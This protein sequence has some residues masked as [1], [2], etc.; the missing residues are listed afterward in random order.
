MKSTA[1]RFRSLAPAGAVPTPGRLF[2]SVLCCSL[3][4]QTTMARAQFSPIAPPVTSSVSGQFVVSAPAQFSWLFN[5]PEIAANTN[6]IRL[7]PALLAVA[8]ERFKVLLWQQV[9]LKA[10]SPWQGKVHLMLRAARSPEDEVTIASSFMSGSWSYQVLLPDVL[11]RARY[12][13]ALSAVL[14]LEI[15][16]RAN[17]SPNRSPEIPAWLVDGLGRQ[18]LDEDEAKLIL[19]LPAGMPNGAPMSSV[20]ERERGL[21]ALASA[22]TI[23]QNSA[24][25]TFD[26]LSWPTEEQM[27]GDDG[28]VYRASAQL[29]VHE[30]LRLPAGPE[31]IHFL[32]ARL[33]GCLN[34]QLA[35]YEAYRSE[36][37]RP[38]EVEKWWSLR[39]I[40]FAAH[41]ANSQLTAADSDERLADLLEVPVQIRG[42]SN[43]L[44]WHTEISLQKAI[45]ELEPGHRDAELSSLLRNLELA[46]FRL[47]RPY[48]VLAAGYRDVLR[49]FLGASDSPHPVTN[50]RREAASKRAPLKDTL[51]KLDALDI[52]RRELAAR[53]NFNFV[54]RNGQSTLR[55]GST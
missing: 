47:A 51:K 44:P 24:T 18:V 55:K 37:K 50:N 15:A 25:L 29:F 35:F 45:R 30:L 54:P 39:A 10:G 17:R 46:Q 27:N 41:N 14:L 43:S 6:L 38:V 13:R 19:S 9:G 20:N 1:R 12:A 4:F 8:V 11:T 32:L 26:Q 40:E 34:W 31:K 21:D 42:N 3:F 16:N 36:F 33:P 52:R 2:L 5:R 22:R 28:G 49:S 7:D 48:A 53:L 23:L